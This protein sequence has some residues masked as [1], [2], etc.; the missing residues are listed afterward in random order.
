MANLSGS[1]QKARVPGG[2][3]ETAISPLLFR[4]VCIL[5]AIAGMLAFRYPAHGLLA[6]FLLA[7]FA[8]PFPARFFRLP[9]PEKR[10]TILFACAF[11]LGFAFCAVTTP[12]ALSPEHYPEWVRDAAVPRTRRVACWASASETA[13]A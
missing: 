8:L 9:L 4:Q 2:T 1:P 6:V 10:K 3:R 5:A 13:C 7:L 11:C 12:S